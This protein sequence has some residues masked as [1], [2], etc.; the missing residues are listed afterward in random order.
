MAKQKLVG[1]VAVITN[2]KRDWH[3]CISKRMIVAVRNGEYSN[4]RLTFSMQANTDSPDRFYALRCNSPLEFGDYGFEASLD[5]IAK[6]K[7]AWDKESAPRAILLDGQ[8]YLDS[9]DSDRFLQAVKKL[10]LT[11]EHFSDALAASEWVGNFPDAEEPLLTFSDGLTL[12][13][14]YNDNYAAH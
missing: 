4:I 1:R 7:K 5:L 13:D 10:G 11:V 12:S 3:T 9:C 6:L 14:A 2:D 8:A